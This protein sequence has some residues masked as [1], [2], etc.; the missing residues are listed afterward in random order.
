MNADAWGYIIIG[1]LW[2][3]LILSVWAREKRHRD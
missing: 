3:L 2:G 1:A